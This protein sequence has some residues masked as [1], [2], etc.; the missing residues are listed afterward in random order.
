[1]CCE[2]KR[3]GSN[4]QSQVWRLEMDLLDRFRFSS[5]CSRSLG[6]SS[7]NPLRYLTRHPRHSAQIRGSHCQVEVQIDPIDPPAHRLPDTSDRLAPPEVRRNKR[8]N[9]PGGFVIGVQVVLPSTRDRTALLRILVGRY[10]GTLHA[11]GTTRRSRLSRAHCRYQPSW[12]RGPAQWPPS[13]GSPRAR[14]S[15]WRGFLPPQPPGP[16]GSPLARGSTS[17]NAPQRYHPCG[18][19]VSPGRWCWRVCCCRAPCPSSWL[20]HCAKYRWG[21]CCPKHKHTTPRANKEVTQCLSR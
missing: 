14:C 12:A 8:A 16:I 2:F 21:S 3:G 19:T 13:A 10:M 9:Y 11:G 20:A 17:I 1:M 15:H 18:R 5:L 6:R 7:C 4:L